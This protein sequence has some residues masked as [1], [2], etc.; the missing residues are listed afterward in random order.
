MNEEIEEAKRFYA[1]EATNCINN[2]NSSRKDFRRVAVLGM[3]WIIL[4]VPFSVYEL[5]YGDRWWNKLGGVLIL[6]MSPVIIHN[7]RDCCRKSIEFY[8]KWMGLRQ[9]CVDR[10][11]EIKKLEDKYKGFTE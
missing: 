8:N 2:A 5:V 3:I 6:V 1:K 4:F 7:T 9:R 11:A 10:L